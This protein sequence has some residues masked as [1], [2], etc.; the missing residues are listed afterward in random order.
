[1][2]KSIYYLYINWYELII[3]VNQNFQISKWSDLIFVH[4]MET[5]ENN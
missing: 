4:T 2:F 3:I 1:M 5:M